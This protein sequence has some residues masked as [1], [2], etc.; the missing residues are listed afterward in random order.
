MGVQASRLQTSWGAG[1]FTDPALSPEIKEF[2]ERIH[3]F[4]RKA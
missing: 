1:F 3:Y 2:Q 4:R